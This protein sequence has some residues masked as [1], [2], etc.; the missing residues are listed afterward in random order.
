MVTATE[1][2]LCKC[3]GPMRWIRR[4]ASTVF[5]QCFK[6]NRKAEEDY[7]GTLT[8]WTI[9]AIEPYTEDES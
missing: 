7:N 9:E 4:Q 6:C 1:R 5:Y 3:G 8:W 2:L